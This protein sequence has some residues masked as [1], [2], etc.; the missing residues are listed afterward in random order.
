MRYRGKDAVKVL[1]NLV[2]PEP[3]DA[4]ALAFQEIGARSVALRTVLRPVNL[5][6]QSRSMRGE[7]GEIRTQGHL[8]PEPRLRKCL[9]QRI[10]QPC[11]GGRRLAP[12][13]S[14]PG[15]GRRRQAR[16]E[17][18]RLRH[19]IAIS[20]SGVRQPMANKAAA[21]IRPQTA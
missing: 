6:D 8:T 16:R 2:V 21:A 14:R 13:R 17:A 5:D 12:Q 10:P 9:A 19:A 15:D 7:V 11:L 4:I 18:N 1:Q 20:Q 3:K